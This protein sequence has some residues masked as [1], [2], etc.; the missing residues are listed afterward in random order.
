M[1]HELEHLSGTII[2]NSGLNVAYWHK[3]A[4]QSRCRMSGLGGG[5]NRS[6]QH[7]L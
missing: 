3:A 7:R 6:L 4:S 1:L 5:L 2:F